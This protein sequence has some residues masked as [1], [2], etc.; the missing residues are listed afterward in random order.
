MLKFQSKMYHLYFNIKLVFLVYRTL[1]T[2]SICRGDTNW[3]KGIFN[4]AYIDPI[5]YLYL[6]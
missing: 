5:N 3:F 6:S 1:V 2:Y 4:T